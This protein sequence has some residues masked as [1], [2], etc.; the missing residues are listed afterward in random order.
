MADPFIGLWNIVQQNNIN[1]IGTE[2]LSEL[3]GQAARIPLNVGGRFVWE[4][5]K[6]DNSPFYILALL[7]SMPDPTP[8]PVLTLGGGVGGMEEMTILVGP[9][10]PGYVD[11]LWKLVSVLDK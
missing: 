2:Y 5:T 3:N 6:P 11:Q 4:V 8:P 9:P 10:K 1:D 7:A